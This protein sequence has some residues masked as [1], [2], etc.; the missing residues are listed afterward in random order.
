MKPELT[1]WDGPDWEDYNPR[2]PDADNR[3]HQRDL[4]R[5]MTQL[6]LDLEP[7]E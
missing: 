7:A 3:N 1:N 2:H 4:E 5:Q 6:A